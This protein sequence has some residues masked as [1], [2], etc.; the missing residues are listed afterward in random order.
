M[1]FFEKRTFCKGNINMKKY[2]LHF[3]NYVFYP[4]K[5]KKMKILQKRYIPELGFVLQ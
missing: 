4:Q 3:I 5:S 2:K 1:T